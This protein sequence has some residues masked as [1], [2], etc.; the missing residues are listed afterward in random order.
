ME[1]TCATKHDGVESKGNQHQAASFREKLM[2]FAGAHRTEEE[3]DWISEDEG[4]DGKK[5]CIARRSGYQRRG[6]GEFGNLGDKRLL[7][8]YWDDLLVTKPFLRR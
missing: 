6:K 3:E 8:N 4:E 1:E 7:S 2:E 5:T